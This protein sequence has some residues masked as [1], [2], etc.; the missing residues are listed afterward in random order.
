MVQY[1]EMATVNPNDIE[2]IEVLKDAASLQSMV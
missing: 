1:Q 2:S